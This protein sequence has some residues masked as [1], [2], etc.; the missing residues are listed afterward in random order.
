LD[1]LTAFEQERPRLFGV[2]YRM[3]GSVGDA[4]DLVQDTWLRWQAADADNVES[5]RAW[6][7]TV[8]SRL[9]IDRLRLASRQREQYI[10]T[11]LPEPVAAAPTP[12][13][14]A[15]LADS[16]SMAFLL[17]LERLSPPERAAYLLREV[18]GAE[19][20][21][22]ARTLER[23]EASCR[24]LVKRAKDRVLAERPRHEVA[25]QRQQELVGAFLS[26]LFDADY[27]RLRAAL[28]EDAV[29]Y[30]DHGGKAASVR[31]NIYTADKIAR[32]FLGLGR[33]FPPRDASFE[34]VLINGSLGI[35]ICECGLPTTALHFAFSTERIETIYQI[36]NPDKLRGL[37]RPQQHDS[38][39]S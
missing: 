23:T 18:F 12:A 25:P 17:L 9:S 37:N 29:L 2:A 3:L 4:E 7:T 35:L 5:P 22:V 30:A 38:S 39:P 1:K 34:P 19:Y 8:I 15:E 14:Q 11:W 6:L 31:R 33:K 24:Q 27:D 26:A 13:A 16:L 21:E 20:D 32:L 28:A 36:R 10:G